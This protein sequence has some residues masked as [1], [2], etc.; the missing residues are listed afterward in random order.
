[1]VLRYFVMRRHT[2]S[3]N[4]LEKNYSDSFFFHV[5]PA[6]GDYFNLIKVL[7]PH[8]WSIPGQTVP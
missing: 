3:K 6:V 2:I 4:R 8:L 7:A 1:M 5:N